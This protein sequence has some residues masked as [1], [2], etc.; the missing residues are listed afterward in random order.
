MNL[1]F[2]SSLAQVA[3]VQGFTGSQWPVRGPRFIGG[4]LG[5]G[6]SHGDMVPPGPSRGLHRGTAAGDAGERQ[7]LAVGGRD[8]QKAGV[9]QQS[10]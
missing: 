7:L 9:L 10:L 3:P 6:K 1:R 4:G 5:P 8:L 2:T